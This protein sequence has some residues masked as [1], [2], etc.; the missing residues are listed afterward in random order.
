[1]WCVDRARRRK[2]ERFDLANGSAHLTLFNFWEGSQLAWEVSGA[3]FAGALDGGGPALVL[4]APTVPLEPDAA[5]VFDGAVRDGADEATAR[6][7][8]VAV[9]AAALE[10]VTVPMRDEP[11]AAATAGG[12]K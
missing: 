12:L 9:A 6:D 7:G 5:A 10:D 2:E 4:P 1:M 8:A 11:S 3:L